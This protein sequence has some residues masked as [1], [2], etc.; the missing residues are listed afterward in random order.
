MVRDCFILVNFVVVLGYGT[1]DKTFMNITCIFQL[2]PSFCG[3]PFSVC[4]SKCA[5]NYNLLYVCFVLAASR[6][7]GCQCAGCYAAADRAGDI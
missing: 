1:V 7:R 2:S 4:S 3:S 5:Y 6:S